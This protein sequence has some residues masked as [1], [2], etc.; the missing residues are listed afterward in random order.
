MDAG[1]QY[2]AFL[3][4]SHDDRRVAA[5]LHRALETYRLPRRLVGREGA[6]GAVPGRLFPVFRDRE[7]LTAS[8]GIGEA[9]ERALAASGALIVLCSPAAA[10][11]RWVDAEISRFVQLHPHAP[12][13]CVLLDGEPLSERECLPP[14]LRERFLA[15][16]G[17]DDTAPVAVDLRSDGDGWRLALQKLVAGLAGVPLD[18]LVQRDAHRRHTR[19][20]WLSAALA[21][22]A[23]AFGTMA[24]FALKARDEARDQRAQ[25]EG[26]IGFMLGDLRQRLEPVGRLDALDAVGAR[27]L[28]YYDRQDPGELDA[29]ALAQRSRA[30]H[31]IGELRDRRGDRAGALL[32]F[33]RAADTTA[34]LLQRAPH[35]AQR[36]YDQAQSVFWVGY[37]SDWQAGR[38]AAAE[39]A[40]LEY[41]RLAQRLVAIDPSNLDWQAELAYSHSNLGTLL[42]R[43]GRVR[44]AEVEFG[45][46]RQAD[47]LRVS[48]SPGDIN[49]ALDLGQDLSWLATAAANGLRLADAERLR[50]QEIGLY[51]RFLHTSPNDS[52]V[53][54]RLQLAQRFLAE[55]EVRL[56][57]YTAAERD[58]NEAEAIARKL[59]ALEPDSTDWQE[60][61]AKTWLAQARLMVA[62]GRSR[63]AMQKLQGVH[64]LLA[65]LLA[66]DPDAWSWKVEVQESL[67]QAE[68]DAL[69]GAGHAREALAVIRASAERLRR[70]DANRGSQDSPARWRVGTEAR[71]ARLLDETGAHADAMAHWRV[72]LAQGNDPSQVPDAESLQLR[73]AT[74]A[75]LGD[76][77]GARQVRAKLAAAGIRISI[78]PTNL[79]VAKE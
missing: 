16:S 15:G 41:Q 67:A 23:L 25:A 32:A 13:L 35:D 36:I 59:R 7:E 73:A 54:S 5:R 58:L 44:E 20:A 28:A 75:A 61:E 10:G 55:D 21:M 12:I 64:G 48:R 14:V 70:L 40:F 4:Y 9:V 63:D 38:S 46:S 79:S 47:A 74:L 2:R 31:M 39:R 29:N 33:Q 30:L 72:A 8:A 60:A 3:S 6:S 71:L 57:E 53:Q 24:V 69:R 19:L 37:A 1:T 45:R 76:K 68:S 56:G 65:S 17:M 26:L 62:T 11:S 42:M 52:T 66:H 78:I 34:I 22:V 77:A 49:A 27:A 18:Q 51:R 50:R 43:Q